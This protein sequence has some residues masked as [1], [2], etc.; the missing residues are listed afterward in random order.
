MVRP[1]EH[2]FFVSCPR[3]DATILDSR[4]LLRMTGREEE[5]WGTLEPIPLLIGLRLKQLKQR[6][7]LTDWL[8]P[9]LEPRFRLRAHQRKHKQTW[10]R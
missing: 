3:L 6:R 8:I 1:L 4:A 2:V 7:L 5:L 9:F 10:R